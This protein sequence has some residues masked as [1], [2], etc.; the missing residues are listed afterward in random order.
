MFI[1]FLKRYWQEIAIAAACLIVMA[2]ISILRHE[3]NAL[4]SDNASLKANEAIIKA[5]GEKQNAESE[6]IETGS[7]QAVQVQAKMYTDD[8]QKVKDYYAKHPVT[9]RAPVGVREPAANPGAVQLPRVPETAQGIA[10]SRGDPD[11]TPSGQSL[12]QDCAIITLQ[13]NTLWQA[14][15]DACKVATCN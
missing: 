13:Y 3:N 9:V 11:T 7:H 10:E 5:I 12:E 8:L 4:R 1:L 6:R 15:D 2:Y 14:W